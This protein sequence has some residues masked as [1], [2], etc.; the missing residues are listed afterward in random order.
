M[1][2]FI[3]LGSHKVCF[4]VQLINDVVIVSGEEQRDSAIHVRVL[5]LPQ[6]YRQGVWEGHVHCCL[7]RITNKDLL[8]SSWSSAQGSV[9]AQRPGCFL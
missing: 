2:S 3:G 5:I 9:A 4:G 1:H 8:C 7:K 6:R